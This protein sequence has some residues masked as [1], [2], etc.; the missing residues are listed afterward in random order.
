[1]SLDGGLTLAQAVERGL[2]AHLPAI[3]AAAEV[4]GKE[5]AIEQVRA[6]ARFAR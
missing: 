1:V 6:G 2:M 3:S 5:H 4:A